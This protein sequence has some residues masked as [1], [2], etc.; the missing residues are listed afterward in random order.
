MQNIKVSVI[1]AGAVGSTLAMRLAENDI[2]DVVL[3]DIAGDIAKGKALDIEDSLSILGVDRRIEGTSDY[4]KIEGSGF[5]VI[6]AGFP[7]KPG[8]TREDLLNKNADVVKGIAQEVKK[9]A[10][11]SIVIVVTNPLDV[12][13]Y[14]TLKVTGFDPSK[15]IGMAGVLDSARIN[16]I[17][18]DKINV[19]SKDL[20]SLV[21]GSH[22]DSMVILPK[23]ITAG[24]KNIENI[25]SADKINELKSSAKNRGA[26]IVNL[27]KSGSAYF[28]P[29][30]AVFSMI[31]N[32][33]EGK[34]NLVC[35][36]CY[37]DG[38]YGVKDVYNGVP[39]KLG[40]NGVTEIIELE[41]SKEEKNEFLESCR[42]VK[43]SISKLN[44]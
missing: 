33:I 21:L 15:V 32:I 11:K 3:V 23:F 8:M 24:N 12:M 6:T 31:K 36:S 17:V 4:A 27:L 29:S 19:S 28:A 40:K 20:N 9:F 22:G 2:S 44:L 26:E 30:Q 18:K 10:K 38:Q 16:S 25:L 42:I 13:S 43:E 34:D 39:A 7:R 37:L 14:L 1:G 5:V 41:L 35:A